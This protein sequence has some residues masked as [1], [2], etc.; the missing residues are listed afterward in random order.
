MDTQ[1]IKPCV[2]VDPIGR[3]MY[4][5]K[6]YKK[7]KKKENLTRDFLVNLENCK[8]YYKK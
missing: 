4:G 2:P 8:T 7:R 6:V 1:A 3:G 5:I